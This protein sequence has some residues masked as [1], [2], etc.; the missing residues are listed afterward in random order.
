MR[1]E[2]E[3]PVLPNLHNA[4]RRGE[5]TH[6]Q[7]VL[8]LFDSGRQR[9]AG[10]KRNIRRLHAA[11]GEVDRGRRFRGPRH[12]NQQDIGLF[13]IDGLLAVV[14]HHRVVERIDAA[15]IFGIEGVLSADFM[16][17]LG[18]EIRLKQVQDRPQNREA[19][20]PEFSAFFLKLCREVLLQ[21]R[22]KHDARRCLDLHKH[23]VELFLRTNKWMHVFDRTDF[24]VLRR[25]RARD[26]DKRFSG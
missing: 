17:R 21:Q 9:D 1:F 14:V 23:P 3:Q 24:C 22:I 4:F 11:V 20:Q 6:D 7:R 18:A 5:K 15:E 8:K 26:G 2:A 12:A 13:E 25:G 10:H 16:G 19:G